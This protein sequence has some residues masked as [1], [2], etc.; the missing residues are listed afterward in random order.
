MRQ[1]ILF[2]DFFGG[3]IQTKLGSPLPGS[4]DVIFWDSSLIWSSSIKMASEWV[5]NQCFQ[6]IT[7]YIFFGK[8]LQ[9]V[10]ELCKKNVFFRAQ[11]GCWSSS[12]TPKWLN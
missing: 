12:N 6:S 5:Q 3:F 2:E 10:G 7:N 9:F 11:F 1:C 8:L 4:L